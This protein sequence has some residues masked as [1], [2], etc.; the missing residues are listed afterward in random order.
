MA[1]QW[2]NLLQHLGAWEGSFDRLDP[3]GNLLASTPTVVTLEGLDD[4]R[5]IRQ[6]IARFPSDAPAPAPQVL[7]Y[8]TLSRNILLFENGSFSMGAG[9]FS[10][11]SQFG[12]EFGFVMGD[13]RLRLV[14]LY[15]RDSHLSELTLIRE[16]AR[17]KTT[18]EGSPLDI[19]RL[20]GS[21]QGTA[22][23]L[24]PDLRPPETYPTQ[25][26]LE[27]QGNC[28]R[29]TLRAPGLEIASEGQ[30]QN[31]RILFS[32]RGPLDYQ[33]L[34][35][36]DGAS[37]NLPP[38]L[39]NRQSFFLEVGWLVA[40]ERRWRLLRNYDGTGNWVNLTLIDER[41]VVE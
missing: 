22:T 11:F 13:R 23:V 14:A 34:L 27:R 17:G 28:L 8:A 3:R 36:P 39:A 9:Q 31:D 20:I 24:Y 29:Q 7:E 35:L 19:G 2:E 37:C 38:T 40:P 30:I 5:R 25:L 18:A 41:K 32:G 12:A 1:S 4:N 10:P 15:D 16:G 33:V 6:T 21:W 26:N